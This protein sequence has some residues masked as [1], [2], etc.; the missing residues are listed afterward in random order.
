[1]SPPSKTKSIYPFGNEGTLAWATPAG[2]LLQ[3][4]SCIDNE[5]I[6]IECKRLVEKGDGYYQKGRMLS[7]AVQLPQGSGCGIGLSLAVDIQPS[8]VSWVQ[9]RWPR[10]TYQYNNLDIKL[11]YYVEPKSRSIIQQYQ[12]CNTAP[13]EVSLPFIV[14]SDA[15]FRR[16]GNAS[17]KSHPIPS[18]KS[19]ERLLLFNNSEVLLDCAAERAQFRMSVFLNAQRL[20]LWNTNSMGNSEEELMDNSVPQNTDAAVDD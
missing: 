14:S 4:A 2:E 15:C 3:I 5:L 17:H 18:G 6:G 8:D 16:H 11:Q 19:H 20:S 10:F 9:N 13:N 7:E 12:I 1:M